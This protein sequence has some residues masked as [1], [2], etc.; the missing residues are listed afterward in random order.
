RDHY[1]AI[2]P[3]NTKEEWLREAHDAV[4]GSKP[5]TAECP[6]CGIYSDIAAVVYFDVVGN[7][8]PWII[9]SSPESEAA[10]REAA[11]DPWFNQI[12]TIGWAP[13]ANRG[14]APTPRPGPIRPELID[15]PTGQQPT[16]HP[17][18]P[19]SGRS[20]YWML[21]ADGKVYPFGAAAG[22][23]DA[24]ARVNAADFEPTPSGN[25]YW[26]VDAGGTVYNFGDAKALGSV[27]R[28]R[29][30]AGETV[31]S[32]SA[33]PTG[34]GYWVFTTKGRAVTFGD[35]VFHGD[36]VRSSLNGAVLDSVP[37]A[38]GNG[39]YM[40]AS[41]GGIFAFGDA[42]FAGSMGGKRL[43]AAVQSLVPDSDGRGYWLVASDGGVFAFDAPFRG[44]MGGAPLN[45]PITGMVPFG[46][47][48]LMVAEDG[49][50]FNFSDQ[51]F[52]GS[53][54]G[55]PPSRPIVAVAAL[56]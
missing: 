12:H 31:T 7:N 33:T 19:P 47:G 23:G 54:G 52:S 26:L 34:N 11:Q 2:S 38:G 21:G 14:D 55:T 32:L 5:R 35:A 49:G 42:A 10:Y 30:A 25:G 3:N 22:L 1:L 24:P 6:W 28:S 13:A 37:T 20:G 27:D 18:T 36:M 15:T 48:Y 41:D 43:N 8:G 16:P 40:V 4:N 9:N 53:L 44:S 17:A 46:N 50:V 39:Y 56:D 45:K 29:L 51:A